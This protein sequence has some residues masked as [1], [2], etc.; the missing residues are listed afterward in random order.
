ML[1][2][3]DFRG[4]APAFDP[5]FGDIEDMPDVFPHHL[6]QGREGPGLVCGHWP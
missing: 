6:I 1:H 2:A 3:E 5:P 4:T